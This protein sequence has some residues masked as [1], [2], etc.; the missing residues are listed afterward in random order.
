MKRTMLFLVAFICLLAD[1]GAGTIKKIEKLTE[2]ECRQIQIAE[3]KILKAQ[4][5]LDSVKKD[6]AKN[7][8]MTEE[9]FME[10]S[11]WF[12]IQ[13]GYIFQHLKTTVVR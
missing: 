3:E 4:G 11:S 10:W 8:N 13:D 1:A 2:E 9:S 7:H 6:I 12:E 5:D